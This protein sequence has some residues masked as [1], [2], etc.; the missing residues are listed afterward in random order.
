M[1]NTTEDDPL[2]SAQTS[3]ANNDQSR[4]KIV[5]EINE[6]MTGVLGVYSLAFDA[7]VKAGPLEECGGCLNGGSGQLNVSS[8]ACMARR[9]WSGRV[10]LPSRDNCM[11]RVCRSCWLLI[12]SVLS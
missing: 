5:N 8:R 7:D 2:Q 10:N 11:V 1:R 6:H 3:R 9:A 12:L 4:S